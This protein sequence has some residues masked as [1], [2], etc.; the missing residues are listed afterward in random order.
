MTPFLRDPVAA[1]PVVDGSRGEL[2]TFVALHVVRSPAWRA[3]HGDQVASRVA[4]AIQDDSDSAEVQM[5]AGRRLVSDTERV[6]ATLSQL[7]KLA[8]SLASMHWSLLRF[9]RAAYLRFPINRCAQC[10]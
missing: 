10:L 5:D 8:S 1:W 3:W 7:T 2:A 9:E 6:K 4:R